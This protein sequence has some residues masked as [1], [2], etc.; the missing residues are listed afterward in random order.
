VF[1]AW[2]S[3]LSATDSTEQSTTASNVNAI[4]TIKKSIEVEQ[5][6]AIV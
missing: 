6:H 5:H 2:G 1:W 3:E 4:A